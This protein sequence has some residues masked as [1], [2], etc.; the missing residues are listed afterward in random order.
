MEALDPVVSALQ[1]QRGLGRGLRRRHREWGQLVQ[2]LV[3]GLRREDQPGESHPAAGP[4]GRTRPSHAGPGGVRGAA[5]PLAALQAGVRA[6]EGRREEAA[7]GR[8]G[9]AV[10]RV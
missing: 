5:R 9:G 6:A 7:V 4:H 2:R 1:Q 10:G 8:R 3:G